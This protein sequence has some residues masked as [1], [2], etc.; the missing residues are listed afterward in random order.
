MNLR[1]YIFQFILIF[2]SFQLTGQE[3]DMYA[4]MYD[5]YQEE[6][7]EITILNGYLDN[8]LPI[9]IAYVAKEDMVKGL[10]HYGNSMSTHI[11]EGI[12]TDSIISLYEFDDAT[13]T[14]VL[15]GTLSGQKMSWSW[16]TYDFSRSL[17]ITIY[18]RDNTDKGQIALYVNTKGKNRSHV[19]VHPDKN[20]ISIQRGPDINLRWM[21]YSCE[22]LYCKE[23]KPDVVLENPI[24]FKID[25]KEL[26]LYPLGSYKKLH[27]LNYEVISDHDNTR[28]SSYCF[29]LVNQKQFDTW[30][31]EL[32]ATHQSKPKKR[33][34][35][36]ETDDLSDRF[37]DRIYGD[38][39][40]TLLSKELL[41][42]FMTFYNTYE[43]R[44]ETVP[45][46]YNMERKRFYRLKDF[47]K[48]DFDYPF[49]IKSVISK[50]K[51]LLINKEDRIVRDILNNEPFGHYV[52]SSEGLVFFSDFNTIY[53]RRHILIPFNE[54]K[55]FIKD[56]AISNYINKDQYR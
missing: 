9:K 19:L 11:L 13:L 25:H 24:E 31:K 4:A 50:Q 52:L 55:S 48:N 1:L 44:M 12:R 17:P 37:K 41:C 26:E 22:A 56:D 10:I 49:F 5:T 15:T 7:S 16:S 51:R 6:Q 28:F 18:E 39:Y 36:L 21:D 23:G 45:F 43:S 42:G 3:I 20:Q 38:F 30:V 53:G 40:I 14:S 8:A 54:M 34:N 46:N 29:P 33:K 35:L 2:L 32:V 27:G 47:F